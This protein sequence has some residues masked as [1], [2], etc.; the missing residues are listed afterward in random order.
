[1]THKIEMKGVFCVAKLIKITIR[2]EAASGI[3]TVSDRS[4]VVWGK[5]AQ[6]DTL[7]RLVEALSEAKQMLAEQALRK[8]GTCVVRETCDKLFPGSWDFVAQG[9]GLEF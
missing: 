6:G 9:G 8:S 1:M 2:E 3:A 5:A 4:I 7:G